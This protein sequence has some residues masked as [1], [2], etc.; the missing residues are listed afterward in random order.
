VARI[1]FILTLTSLLICLLATTAWIRGY[2]RG[3]ILHVYTPGGRLQAVGSYAGGLII[4]ITDIPGGPDVTW[5]GRWSLCRLDVASKL[6][7][8][9]FDQQSINSS[10]GGFV[11]A[12][13]AVPVGAQTP[14]YRALRVPAWFVVALT[15][16]L[17]LHTLRRILRR[18]RWLKRG[19]CRECGYDLRETPGRCPECGLEP[20]A[21]TKQSAPRGG[22]RYVATML[23]IFGV[24]EFGL[25]F[26]FLHGESDRTNAV[27][28]YTDEEIAAGL[29]RQVP[30]V[31][32]NGTARRHV[33]R[34]LSRITRTPIEIDEAA[35]ERNHVDLDEPVTI[36]LHDAPLGTTIKLMFS[37][38][39]QVST[40]AAD[41]GRGVLLTAALDGAPVDGDLR[42]V[43]SV[44]DVSRLVAPWDQSG[45]GPSTSERE[46][47]VAV[48]CTDAMG[49]IAWHNTPGGGVF[50]FGERAVVFGTPE[51]QREVKVLIEDF[52]RAV[53]DDA[54]TT[55]ER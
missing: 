15:A 29:N 24:L 26:Q 28:F 4:V 41:S 43:V 6:Y 48:A 8:L 49:R 23:A 21:L 53:R 5:S 44:Y 9:A 12:K 14:T 25:T 40:R 11:F 18:R 55:R 17:P 10:L 1:R 31:A 22:D 16:P 45:G 3:D 51:A 54:A 33:L 2:Q 7:D 47:D 36:R 19:S 46:E 38:A 35:F 50:I 30:D 27:R 52:D 42:T 37:T 13:G 32:F 20:L 39:D 34:E